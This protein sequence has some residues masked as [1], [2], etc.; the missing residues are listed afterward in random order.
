MFKRKCRN[1]LYKTNW[2]HKLYPKV[3]INDI[4]VDSF[5]LT[6]SKLSRQ[7]H[8]RLWEFH[9]SFQRTFNVLS[10]CETI[11]YQFKIIRYSFTKYEKFYKRKPIFKNMVMSYIYF[12]NSSFQDNKLIFSKYIFN[13]GYFSW[14]D[15]FHVYQII[16]T[17][18]LFNNYLSWNLLL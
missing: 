5:L 14:E 12:S 3:Q 2:E 4:K 11:N 10:T 15:S 1:N 7:K 9:L 16:C 17:C 18:L 8:I 13:K 6:N